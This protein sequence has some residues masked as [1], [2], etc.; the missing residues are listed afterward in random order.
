MKQ[1]MKPICVLIITILLAACGTVSTLST[2]TATAVPSL[3]PITPS[4]TSVFANPTATPT[5]TNTPTATP[6]PGISPGCQLIDEE[7]KLFVISYKEFHAIGPGPKKLDQI[8][9]DHFPEWASYQQAV[10]WSTAPE[11]LGEIINSGSTDVLSWSVNSSVALVTLGEIHRWE[12]PVGKDLFLE[13]KQLSKELFYLASDWVKPENQ[14]L[15]DRY[16]HVS[17]E[18]TY[19]L[20]AYFDY[21]QDK[22]QSWCEM[23]LRLFGVS[24][25]D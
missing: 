21:D 3:T 7:G 19:A 14:Q 1:S 9:S 4:S 22:L 20:Y 10:T 13:T 25:L 15:R 8:L 12:I 23:Y 16:A 2:V 5:H 18:G 24:S 17:N 11:K 6:E